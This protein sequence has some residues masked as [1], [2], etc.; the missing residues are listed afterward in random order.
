MF[1][2]FERVEAAYHRRQELEGV[3]DQPLTYRYG[4]QVLGRK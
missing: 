2:R 4:A 1:G 3:L